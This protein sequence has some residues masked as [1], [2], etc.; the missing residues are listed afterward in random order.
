MA[1]GL[2][3]SPAWGSDLNVAGTWVTAGGAHV[4][5][6]NCGDDTPCGELV[7]YKSDAGM[8]EL[9]TLN[10]DPAMREN[11]LIGTMIVWGFEAKGD[12]WK[13]GKIYDAENGKLY[14]SKMS[15]NEDGTLK[16]KGCVGPICQSQTW[17]LLAPKP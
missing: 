14:K 16:V 17:T 7:W 13:S 12:K 8:T 9:D 3:A 15:M 5:I 11:P 1:I 4:E 6:G 2:S 10:P